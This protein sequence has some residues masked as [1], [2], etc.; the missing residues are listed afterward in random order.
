MEERRTG[1]SEERRRRRG[2]EEEEEGSRDRDR[3]T[4]SGTDPEG[5]EGTGWGERKGG[6]ERLGPVVQHVLGGHDDEGFCVGA[7]DLAPQH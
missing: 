7:V 1:D 3:E 2:E 6:R 5:K 4:E